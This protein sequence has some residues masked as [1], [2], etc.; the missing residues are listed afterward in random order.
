MQQVLES[1]PVQAHFQQVL[2]ELASKRH[3]QRQPHRAARSWWPSRRRIDKGE[4]TDKGSINQRAV[5]KHRA[6]LVDALHTDGVP[7][8]LQTHWR[9]AMKIEGQAALVTGGAS[10]LGEATARELA[11]LGAKVAVLDRNAELADQG[12]RG[13]RRRG[14]RLRHH[15][16]RQ[17]ERR[18]R[19]G[20]RG[21][22]PGAHPD[23]HRRHRQRQAHRRQG[24]QR[25]AAGRLRARGQRQPDRRL[26][27]QPPVRRRAAP[28]STAW[29]TASAA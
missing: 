28:S 10:G 24:R 26:Q 14:L 5:L 16:H 23:E 3:R 12:G 27:H 21:A 9:Q 1:A 18:A 17:R 7:F 13:H 25:R 19:Q 29:T 20:R 15:R 2:G 22:R 4:I 8:I 6:A 11:R